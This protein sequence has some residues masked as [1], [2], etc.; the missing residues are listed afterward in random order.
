MALSFITGIERGLNLPLDFGIYTRRNGRGRYPRRCSDAIALSLDCGVDQSTWSTPEVRLPLFSVTRFT[1]RAL[2]LNEQELAAVKRTI[3]EGN[4]LFLVGPRRFGKT[5]ILKTAADELI[6]DGVIIIRLDAES[7]PT[8]DLLVAA[9][10]SSAAKAMQGEVRRVGATIKKMFALLRPELDYSL[11]DGEW[12]VKFGVESAKLVKPVLLIDALNGLEKLAKF[13]PDET[14]V[15]FILDEL[16]GVIGIGGRE[17]EGQIRAA[18]QIHSKMVFERFC[19][20]KEIRA[21][22]GCDGRVG[23]AARE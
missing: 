12:S 5:S 11:A 6:Q 16:Q 1:A 3:R 19:R 21:K 15:G 8:L 13:Q 18:I 14:A 23:Y 17:V 7:F 20:D 2:P 10:V 22:K 9:I 4:K